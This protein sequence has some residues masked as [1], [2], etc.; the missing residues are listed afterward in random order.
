MNMKNDVAA[1]GR[2]SHLDEEEFEGLILESLDPETRHSVETH[3]TYCLACRSD[4]RNLQ[5]VICDFEHGRIEPLDEISPTFSE[6]G[7]GQIHGAR[8]WLGEKSYSLRAIK[9]NSTIAEIRGLSINQLWDMR[10][11]DSKEPGTYFVGIESDAMIAFAP[12]SHFAEAQAKAMGASAREE[13]YDHLAVDGLTM[14]FRRSNESRPLIPV[15]QHNTG[16]V[17]MEVFTNA[18]GAVF[19]SAALSDAPT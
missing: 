17:I 5:Q 12:L 19:I 9:A 16:E 13:S 11:S 14:P 10:D 8:F 18:S 2:H 4:L 15:L 6:K 3:L 1:L 7:F